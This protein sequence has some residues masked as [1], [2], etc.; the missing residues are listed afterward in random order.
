VG[1]LFEGRW[2]DQENFPTD[3]SGAFKRPDSQFRCSAVIDP[4]P[5][6]YHLYL[7]H[8]CPWC[9]R[10]AIA[11]ELKG[12][13]DV[14]SVSFVHPLLREGGWRFAEGYED[15]LFGSGY[16]HE[17]YTRADAAYSGRVTVPVL[18]DRDQGTIACNES[19]DLLR[20]FDR[21]GSG[22]ALFPEALQ[23]EIRSINATIYPGINNGVY[24]C[25]FARTQAAYEEAYALLFRTLDQVSARLAERPWL[26]GDQMTEAD[27]RLYVT[28]VRFDAVYVGHFKCNRNRIMDDPVLQAWLERLYAIPAFR[29]T[30]RLDEIKLHYYG[31]HRGLNPTGIVPTGPRLPWAV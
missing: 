12:L 31:S 6:R 24:R 19:E 21:I 13:Q 18:W 29:D 15:P 23:D 4:R 10:T 1:H 25:G 27:I 30:T 5:G 9:H 11:R 26:V 16:V 17:L 22:P 3:A 8:A 20:L 2:T 7:A 28:L 14:I